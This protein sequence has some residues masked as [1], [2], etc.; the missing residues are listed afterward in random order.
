MKM[1]EYR[2][3]IAPDT[4]SLVQKGWKFMQ[5]IINCIRSCFCKHDFELLSRCGVVDYKDDL[6]YRYEWIYRCRK[7]GFVQKIKS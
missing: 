3:P 5:W 2:Y 4:N 7:C 1:V 6:P